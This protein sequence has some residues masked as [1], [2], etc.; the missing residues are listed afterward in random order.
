MFDRTLRT[1]LIRKT[2]NCFG[3]EGNSNPATEKFWTEGLHAHHHQRSAH[4]QNNPWPGTTDDDEEAFQRARGGDDD[5][6]D[7]TDG[8]DDNNERDDNEEKYSDSKRNFVNQQH[9]ME[10]KF[11]AYIYYHH[12]FILFSRPFRSLFPCFEFFSR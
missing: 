11:Q 12:F 4:R 9:Y 5:D 3:F 8:H 1:F 7:D 10:W 2:E 6:D